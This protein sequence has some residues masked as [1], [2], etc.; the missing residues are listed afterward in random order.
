MKR[1]R[2]TTRLKVPHLR[3]TR[4]KRSLVKFYHCF[5]YRSRHH[6]NYSHYKNTEYTPI[7]RHSKGCSYY[8]YTYLSRDLCPSA[9]VLTKCA[10]FSAPLISSIF[11][12]LLDGSF[13]YSHYQCSNLIINIS[14][15]DFKIIG[16][17]TRAQ[18]TSGIRMNTGPQ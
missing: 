18:G 4:S 3:R 14:M 7:L 16:S 8:K 10:I 9:L 1:T 13:K 17:R 15:A 6:C 11:S 5:L 12:N 2:P